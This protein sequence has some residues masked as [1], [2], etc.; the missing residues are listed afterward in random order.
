[1]DELLTRWVAFWSRLGARGDIASEG[2]RLLARYDEPW[3]H[4]HTRDHLRDLYRLFDEYRHLARDPDA[5]EA[6]IPLHDAVYAIASSTNEQD[7]AA[8]TLETIARLGVAYLITPVADIVLATTHAQASN[9][10]D[11]ALF[12]DLDLAILGADRERYATY[13]D[14]IRAEYESIYTPR[15]YCVG[16]QVFLHRFLERVLASEAVYTTAPLR[17]RFGPHVRGNLAW[18]IELLKERKTRLDM[19]WFS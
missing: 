6:A 14:A 15:E 19:E 8:L 1:M 10:P 16:R 11:T 12:C 17:E 5:V 18:E 4:Y 3:R 13:A 9:D 7:S 2:E